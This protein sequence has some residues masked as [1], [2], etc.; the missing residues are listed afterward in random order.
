MKLF[1]AVFELSTKAASGES[2]KFEIVDGDLLDPVNE[3]LASEDRYTQEHAAECIA[4]LLTIQS[5]QVR[6]CLIIFK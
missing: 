1:L 5:I 4:E 6:H 2:E 3:L